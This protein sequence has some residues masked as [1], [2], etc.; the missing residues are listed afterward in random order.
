Q[1]S[2][3]GSEATGPP[4]QDWTF[5]IGP[6]VVM[7]PWFEGGAYYGVLPVPNLDLRCVAR[8][9]LRVVPPLRSCRSPTLIFAAGAMCSSCRRAMASA[10]RSSRP[11]ASRPDRS[12]ATDVHATGG[13]GGGWP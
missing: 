11:L 1:P 8:R 12:C 13:T 7:A 9:A 5:D 10:P 2:S 4:P 3:I 6:G